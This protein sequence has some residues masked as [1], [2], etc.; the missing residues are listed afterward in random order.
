MVR[1][2]LDDVQWRET[3]ELFPGCLLDEG[4]EGRVDKLLDRVLTLRGPAPD[5]AT[6]ARIAGIV[7]RLL[8][9]LSVYQYLPREEI[10]VAYDAAL[11][12]SM[13]I[14]TAAGAA[15]VPVKDRIAA[16]EALGRGGDP[17]LAA[18]RD[19]FIEVPGCCGLR[20]G[21]YPVTVEEYQRFVEFRG[22]EEEKHWVAEGWARR[23]KEGWEQPWDWDQQL[24]TPN[25]PV[26]GVSWYE[27]VAYCRW[28]SEQRSEQLRLPTGNEWEK[29]ATS[30]KGEYSW[31]EE[32]PDAERAN[33][34]ANVGSAT[35]VG[36]YPAGNG[37]F[38]HSDLAGNV[39]EWCADEV[40]VENSEEVWKMVR[41][42]GWG[43]PAELLR[44]AY[45][46]RL[47]AGRRHV[48]L[49]FRVAVAP[50]SL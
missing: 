50:A 7:G 8:Q 38:G 31:G 24:A 44:A 14:F 36:I 45:R 18:E 29:A 25:R 27:A 39:W 23:S 6:E 2:R 42:G 49:G 1:E 4:G 19:N 37:P 15:E 33:F 17:R 35:P 13:A 9:P 30:V 34:K 22:Y 12:R 28:L 10:A 3:I 26:I 48:D 5:L 11:E 47:P 41:G 32:E 16:A 43:Y 20:L 40:P 46:L 21:K